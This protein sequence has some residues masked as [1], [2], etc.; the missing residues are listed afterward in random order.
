VPLGIN[1]ALWKVIPIFA[2]I[3]EMLLLFALIDDVQVELD[4][5]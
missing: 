5:L 3:L 1:R 2:K 4:P